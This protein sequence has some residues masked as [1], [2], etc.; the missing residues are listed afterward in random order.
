MITVQE[1]L[2][3]LTTGFT[4]ELYLPEDYLMITDIQYAIQQYN[5]MIIPSVAPG[6]VLIR[7]RLIIQD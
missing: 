1:S 5:W 4:S 2:Y 7:R 3:L 6:W